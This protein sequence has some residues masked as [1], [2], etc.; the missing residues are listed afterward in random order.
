MTIAEL[1]EWLGQRDYLIAADHLA[2][3]GQDRRKGVRILAERCQQAA[4]RDQ[5]ERQRLRQLWTLEN[6]QWQRGM[7][8]IAGIDEAGC[9]PLAGPVVAA[10]VVFQAPVLI[11]HLNDSK[12]LQVQKRE[13][14]YHAIYAQAAAVGVGVV[15]NQTIDA[16]NILESAKIAMKRAVADLP[17]LPDFAFVDGTEGR[18]PA[19]N[20]PSRPLKGGDG[21]SASVA[22]AS[23]IAKVSRDRMME[24]LDA[25]YPGYGFRQH[26]GY[27]SSKHYAALRSLGASPVHRQSFLKKFYEVENNEG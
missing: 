12:K 25:T 20:I 13:E 21:R 26:K 3:L 16:L 19:W 18:M 15:G 23:I 4:V 17:L 24:E 6:R 11:P 27:P 9:G 10:A 5:A 14:L 1:R 7:I 8:T 22:A 2:K